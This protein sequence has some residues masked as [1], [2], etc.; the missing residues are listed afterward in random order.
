MEHNIMKHARVLTDTELQAALRFAEVGRN[1]A[2]NRLA[3]AFSHYAG[4]RA[5][6]LASLKW[7]DVLEAKGGIRDAI[8][9]RAE[10]TKGDESRTVF[11]ADRLRREISAYL[12]AAPQEGF[13]APVLASQKGGHFTANTLVQLF[14]SIY[15]QANLQG[16]T[17]HSGRRW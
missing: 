7:T 10:M 5:C 11:V 16:A 1:G 14:G 17:S 8:H 15:A 9:L 6:E 2:R 4:L 3:V 13:E 12:K